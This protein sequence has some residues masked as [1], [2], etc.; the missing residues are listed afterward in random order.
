MAFEPLQDALETSR[1]QDDGLSALERHL[2]VRETQEECERELLRHLPEILAMVGRGESHAMLLG[3]LRLGAPDRGPM[4][5]G[6][7]F[8]VFLAKPMEHHSPRNLRH[9]ELSTWLRRYS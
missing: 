1:F 5:T 2:P 9:I 8:G 7:H 3:R 6:D 4:P